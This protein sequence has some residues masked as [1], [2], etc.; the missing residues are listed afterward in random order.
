MPATA[1]YLAAMSEEKV[2]V[3]RASNAAWNAGKMDAFFETLHPDVIVQTV[4]NWPEPG[5]HVGREAAMRFYR[6]LRAAFDEDRLRET[7][8]YL[9]AADRVVVRLA[10]DTVGHGPPV[11]MEASVVFSVRKG[12][13]RSVEFFWDHE[14]ALEAA[15][16]Q[17]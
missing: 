11:P 3:I 5:P 9:H 17:A 16:L 7:S 6:G 4:G 10:M 2:A 15:G 8:E 14:E 1:R 12:T 13:I